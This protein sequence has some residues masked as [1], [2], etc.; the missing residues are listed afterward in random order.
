MPF[1]ACFLVII[2]VKEFVKS[3]FLLGNLNVF[4]VD[5]KYHHPKYF[6]PA[7][8]SA[9]F[10]FVLWFG[11]KDLKVCLWKRL[12]LA[13]YLQSTHINLVELVLENVPGSALA[14]YVIFNQ[15]EFTPDDQRVLASASFLSSVLSLVIGLIKV[16]C[17]IPRKRKQRISQLT[18]ADRAY[19]FTCALIK[20]E[21]SESLPLEMEQCVSNH[22]RTDSGK[23]EANQSSMLDER[24]LPGRV[25][26]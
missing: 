4:G 22:H 23:L 11:P 17:V 16:S 20:P 14:I 25:P 6:E 10:P 18:V 26:A 1:M 5:S 9:F 7:S 19:L 12:K 13:R 21:N 15:H 8:N 2:L 3:I 24:N